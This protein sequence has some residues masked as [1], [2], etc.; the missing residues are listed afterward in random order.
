LLAPTNGS[1]TGLLDTAGT[2]G[3]LLA[4]TTGRTTRI[5]DRTPFVVGAGNGRAGHGD[6]RGGQN[7]TGG[8]AETD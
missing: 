5:G 4:P 2:N 6:E 3:R 1:T 8:H 7:S